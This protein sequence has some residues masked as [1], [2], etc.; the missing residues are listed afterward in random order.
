[1]LGDGDDVVLLRIHHLLMVEKNQ[2]S[3]ALYPVS[4]VVS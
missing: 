1:M 4:D 2:I 3:H